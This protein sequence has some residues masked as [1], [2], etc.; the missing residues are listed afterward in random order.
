VEWWWSLLIVVGVFVVRVVTFT[1][2]E[3]KAGRE[4]EPIVLF[5]R[6]ATTLDAERRRASKGT[7]TSA[8]PQAAARVEMMHIQAEIEAL[9]GRGGAARYGEL[10][11]P[12]RQVIRCAAKEIAFEQALPVA[13]IT[14]DQ[15]RELKRLSEL[16]DAALS[17]MTQ[18]M[19]QSPHHGRKL[20]GF[21]KT[22][23][24]AFLFGSP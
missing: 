5:R 13:R 24:Y 4:I 21:Q 15:W 8:S 1:R 20:S 2:S 22:R 7:K 17:R 6:A 16:T 12:A 23:L 18:A 19:S 3:A 10:Y 14:D 9:A 11:E